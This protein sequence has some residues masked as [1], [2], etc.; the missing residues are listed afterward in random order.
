MTVS[1]MVAV[2]LDTQGRLTQLNVVTPQVDSTENNA[3]VD[4]SRLF[5]AAGLPMTEFRSV[6]PLWV[7]NGYAD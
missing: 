3:Q 4:W 1:N 6:Q 7:P 2:V 5:E